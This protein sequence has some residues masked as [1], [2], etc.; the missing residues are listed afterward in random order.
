MIKNKLFEKKVKKKFLFC[1]IFYIFNINKP[2]YKI[3]LKKK[4]I[5]NI[6]K[7]KENFFFLLNL[8]YNSLFR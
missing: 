3:K 6:K 1:I 5:L 4:L 8:V 2:I 7:K